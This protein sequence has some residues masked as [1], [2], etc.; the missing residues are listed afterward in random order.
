[1][2]MGYIRMSIIRDENN[3]PCDYRVTDANEVSSTFFGLPLESYIG[4][5]ASEKHPDYLQK[6]N[7]LEEILDSNSYR[8]KDEYFPRTERYT[9]W[10]IYSPG[11]D[12]IVGLFLDSTAVSYTHLTL[13]TN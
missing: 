12:E 7:F 2:P 8:E 6:L 11:K 5:L 4:S 1:M 13:P 9:H 10:V 3:K